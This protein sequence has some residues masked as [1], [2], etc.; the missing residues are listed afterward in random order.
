M[1]SNYSIVF[2]LS[3]D[4]FK[5]NSKYKLLLEDESGALDKGFRIRAAELLLKDKITKKIVIVGGKNEKWKKFRPDVMESFF[6]SDVD[7]D[8]IEK[9]YCVPGNTCGN[10]KSIISYISEK[11]LWKQENPMGI[12]TNKYHLPRIIALFQYMLGSFK[13]VGEKEKKEILAKIK[14]IS[15]EDVILKLENNGQLDSIRQEI[16]YFYGQESMRKREKS[17]TSGLQEIKKGSYVC[18][19]D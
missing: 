17:E 18:S 8:S 12:L 13:D 9:L 16:E 4:F 2:L 5:L 3:V 10:A 19:W 14:K 7:K 15:A 11:K 1:K 6:T